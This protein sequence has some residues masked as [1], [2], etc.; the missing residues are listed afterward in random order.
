MASRSS[1][2]PAGMPS[3][4]TTSACPCDSPAVRNRSIRASIVYEVSAHSPAAGRGSSS[5]S[6]VISRGGQL[7]LSIGQTT[8]HELVADRFVAFGRTWID[9]ASGAPVRLRFVH[10]AQVSEEII[11]NEQCAER[12]R[13]RHPLMN[14]LVDYGVAGN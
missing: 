10:A 8:M 2:R 3:R 4:I 6:A 1:A 13:L 5:K 11:W 14:V 7:A 12:A 9:I